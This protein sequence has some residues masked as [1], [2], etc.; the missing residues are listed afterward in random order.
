MP[1]TTLGRGNILY[2]FLIQVS[3]TPVSVGASTAAEQNFTI[4]GLQVGDYADINC[5]AAQTAGLGVGNVRISSANT[6]TVEFTNSTAGAL[7]PTAGLYTLNICRPENQPLPS[8][9]V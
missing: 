5:M 4:Q 6:L 3:L 8:N 7:V 1:G 2:D 9:A